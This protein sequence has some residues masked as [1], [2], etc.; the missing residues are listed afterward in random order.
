MAD[1]TPAQ[2]KFIVRWSEIGTRWG[3]NRTMAR[4]HALLIVASRPLDAEEIA[5]MLSVSRSNVSTSLRELRHWGLVRLVHGLGDSRDQF[6]VF[7]DVWEVGWLILDERKRREFDPAVE[8]LRACLADADQADAADANT[9]RR[10]REML[11]LF[12]MMDT[13]YAQM[14]RLPRGTMVKLVK[15]GLKVQK[16]LLG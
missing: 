16:L 1:L 5:R 2:R 13:W 11:D 15:M 12:E 4:V 7:Q 14:R 6:E 10:L 8:V 9:R 3:I